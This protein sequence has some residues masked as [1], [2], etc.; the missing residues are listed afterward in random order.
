MGKNLENIHRSWKRIKSSQRFKNTWMFL[1]FVAIALV[2][3]IIIVLNDNIIKTFNVKLRITNVPDSVTFITLPPDEIHVTLR[4]K[5]TKIVRS[6][7]LQDQV[8]NIDFGEY[9]NDGVLRLT[10]SDLLAQ[11]KADLGGGAQI[12]SASIDSLRC[13]YTTSPGKRVPVIVNSDLTAASGYVI[14]GAPMPTEKSVL[15]YSYGNETDTVQRVYT[16]R[17][18]K[19][20]LS[21]S[22]SYTVKLLPLAGVRVIPSSIKVNV[23]VEALVHKE[24]YVT[25]DLLN[26]PESENLLLFPPKVPVSFFVPMSRFN[27]DNPS[28][29]VVA[30]YNDINDTN[31]SMLPVRITASATDLVNV[32]LLTDSV[33][34]TLVK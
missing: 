14:V 13:Y 11:L 7:L 19:K 23:N 5:G 32:K 2:F 25:V 28:V 29:H 26:V 22:G 20:D 16:Q 31:T 21:Q 3:W 17:L 15:V 4:D 6:G 1:I 12:S 24:V 18:V 8:L 33:E 27:D 34:Y 10:S 30:D 9:A